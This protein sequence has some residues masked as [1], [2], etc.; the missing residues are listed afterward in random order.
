M[1]TS[2]L[3]RKQ[4]NS[5]AIVR[6][7]KMRWG[8]EVEFRGL[9]QT[10]DRAKL[11]SRND[12]RVMA[13]LDWSILAMAVAELLALKEQ[14]VQP[15]GEAGLPLEPER[16]SLANTM[17]AIRRCLRRLDEVS[18][19]GADLAS[20]LRAARTD[21]YRRRS[22][23]RARYRPKNPDKKPLGDPKIRLLDAE[24][25]KRLSRRNAA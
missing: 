2:V 5:R 3:S 8:V 13:E 17:R 21:G 23:K 9:K 19:L 12:R 25:R 24:E 14:Q 16:R 18:P 1:L 10:L 20:R 22:S 15:C 6:L 7:Y 11:R 4:L